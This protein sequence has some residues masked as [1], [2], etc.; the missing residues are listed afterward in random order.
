LPN[1]SKWARVGG[2]TP[3]DNATNL[4]DDAIEGYE[5]LSGVRRDQMLE[6]KWVDNSGAVYDEFND[7]VHV[8]T[9]CQRDTGKC[10]RIFNKS[11]IFI[12]RRAFRSI[13][14]GYKDPFVCLWG[15]LVDEQLLIYRSYYKR[16]KIVAVHAEFIK[17]LQEKGEHITWTVA[18]HDAE[19]AA[20][21]RASGVRNRPAKKD[22]PRMAGVERV[23][24]RLQCDE[25]G[26]PGLQICKFCQ[27]VIDEMYS[28]MMDTRD[29][30]DAPEKDKNDHA[31]DS[32]RYMVADLDGRRKSQAHIF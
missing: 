20:T 31:M 30:V 26:K 11:G 17:S 27:P 16:R 32:L 28:Y 29:G 12:P 22:R 1:A 3:Y 24:K 19:D 18:D 10:P 2:W 15:A 5:S 23:K 4:A 8:C 7:K 14:F 25:R 6:G 9:R 13:D 21:L